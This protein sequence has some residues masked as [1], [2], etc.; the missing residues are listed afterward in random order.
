MLD[1][2]KRPG[3]SSLKELMKM[4]GGQLQSVRGFSA[5]EEGGTPIE[6]FKM[7]IASAPTASVPN[8]RPTVAPPGCHAR[9][10]NW[11]AA[12]RWLALTGGWES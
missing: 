7:V 2:P 11:T 6:D 5:Q 1:L 3:G 4:T 9:S 10:S 8:N 12:A